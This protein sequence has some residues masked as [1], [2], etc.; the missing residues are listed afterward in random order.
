[1]EGRG[2]DRRKPPLQSWSVVSQRDK[3]GMV[4]STLTTDLPS[5]RRQRQPPTTLPSGAFGFAV[6]S[7]AALAVTWCASVPAPVLR[8]LP[9]QRLPLARPAPIS[10]VVPILV[11]LD[12]LPPERRAAAKEGITAWTRAFAKVNF[13]LDV[14]FEP[15]DGR[16][17]CV[18]VV[19]DSSYGGPM[20]EHRERI[21]AFESGSLRIIFVRA[22]WILP[23]VMAHEFGHAMGLGELYD[24]YGV[25]GDREHG[26]FPNTAEVLL[27]CRTNRL[28]CEGVN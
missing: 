27:V 20:S 16:H 18:E 9:P 26:R 28:P 22:E 4:S 17:Q 21:A 2:L 19:I 13:R 7:A 5:A 23:H 6:A 10:P 3:G 15:C 12:G 14:R 8:H 24:V 25:M 11:S 1:M